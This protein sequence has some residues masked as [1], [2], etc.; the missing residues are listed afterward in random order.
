MWPFNLFKYFFWFF[1]WPITLLCLVL[2]LYSAS[3]TAQW[4]K[5]LPAM[6]EAQETQARSLGGE[7]PLEEAR[8]PTQCSCWR[9]PRTE[10]PGGHSP[11][12]HASQEPVRAWLA[13][14][15]PTCPPLLAKV[16]SSDEA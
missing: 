9:I 11:R 4:L 6:Q 1:L 14:G 10:E 5:N 15:A 12:G 7:D 8:Q 13:S 2:S 3:P 16:G